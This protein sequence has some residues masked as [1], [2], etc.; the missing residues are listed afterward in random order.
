MREQRVVRDLREVSSER[1]D[2]F[3][4]VVVAKK[5]RNGVLAGHNGSGTPAA[6]RPPQT[7]KGLKP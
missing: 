4:M 5:Q 7:G 1:G 3:A 2:C 6:A